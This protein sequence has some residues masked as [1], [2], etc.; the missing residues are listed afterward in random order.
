[1]KISSWKLTHGY[2]LTMGGFFVEYNGARTLL[3]PDDLLGLLEDSEFSL[4]NIIKEVIEARSKADWFIKSLALIQ[5]TCFIIQV[6]GRVDQG[7]PTTTL[8]LFTLEVVFCAL[9][10]YIAWWRKPHDVRQL[11]VIPV[12]NALPST[13]TVISRTHL[14]RFKGKPFTDKWA[15]FYGLWVAMGFAA[16]HLVG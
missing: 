15:G 10:T 12:N 14:S 6:G 3:H 4:P 2:L 5:A 9:I 13:S 7:L 1:M 8:E 16:L 11:I